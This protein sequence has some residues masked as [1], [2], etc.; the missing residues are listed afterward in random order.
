MFINYNNPRLTNLYKAFVSSRKTLL[1]LFFL[2]NDSLLAQPTGCNWPSSNNVL[3][4]K[5]PSSRHA[6]KDHFSSQSTAWTP[7]NTTKQQQQQ[8]QQQQHQQQHKH[9]LSKIMWHSQ[10]REKNVWGFCDS[11]WFPLR[12][13]YC[14]K[15]QLY[16]ACQGGWQV[17]TPTIS[18]TITL[19]HTNIACGLWLTPVTYGLWLIAYGLC[20]CCCFALTIE[21]LTFKKSAITPFPHRFSIH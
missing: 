13:G 18:I 3:I 2:R 4:S 15:R 8:Q 5:T 17:N 7:A 16:L 21:G 19:T 1:P 6:M 9:K 10:E 11:C 20:Y 12:K 14:L